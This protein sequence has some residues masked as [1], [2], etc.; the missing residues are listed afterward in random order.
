MIIAYIRKKIQKLYRTLHLVPTNRKRLAPER[1]LRWL[2]VNDLPLHRDM[3]VFHIG[4]FE[5]EEGYSLYLCGN[6]TY[7]PKDDGNWTI[8]A[9]Y[10]PEYM[11]LELENYILA[12]KKNKTM[13]RE[14]FLQM[15]K[16]TITKYLNDCDETSMFYQKMVTTGFDDGDI[17]VISN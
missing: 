9:D 1:I 6:Q 17:E 15:T 14:E 2:K 12:S 7:N 11:Y 13:N 16:D 10:E 5:T 4:L 8:E 3:A